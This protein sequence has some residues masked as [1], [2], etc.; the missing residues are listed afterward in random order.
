MNGD[1]WPFPSCLAGQNK[2]ELAYKTGRASGQLQGKT[3]LHR[4]ISSK[5]KSTN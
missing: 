5:Q 2:A 1:L 3:E 4:P